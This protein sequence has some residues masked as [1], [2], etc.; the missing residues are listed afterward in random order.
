[1][2][3]SSVTATT[4]SRLDRAIALPVELET[5][6]N[7]ISTA[8]IAYCHEA[9][10]RSR[11]FNLLKTTDQA[12]PIMQYAF[13]QYR[14][15]RDRLHQWF[16][17][18]IVKAGSCSEPD[19]KAA[20]MSLADHIFTDLRDDHTELYL[21]FLQALQLGPEAIQASRRSPATVAYERSFFDAHGYGTENFY[22]ALVALSGRELC[23]SIRNHQIL[24]DYF[25][26]QNLKHPL[27]LAL[28]AELEME[29]FQ[30]VLRPALAHY[31]GSSQAVSTLLETLQ[32]SI[33]RHVQY[34]EEMLCEYEALNS[35][36]GT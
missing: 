16:G 27:W 5:R 13:L 21:E 28:H 33:N 2:K 25:D 36:S 20:L 30:D 31:A 14:F 32:R 4:S 35:G 23:V 12:L 9:L 29:H 26:A 8:A 19:Q 1:M 6:V 15:W 10:D 22:A 3:A 24:R 17:L 34:F 11:F 18:C 7:A